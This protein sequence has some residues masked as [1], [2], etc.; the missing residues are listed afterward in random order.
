MPIYPGRNWLLS[1]ACPSLGAWDTYISN[2]SNSSNNSGA[3]GVVFPRFSRIQASKN[4]SCASRR[5][6]YSEYV[7]RFRNDSEFAPLGD[8]LAQPENTQN[9]RKTLAKAANSRLCLGNNG[10]I[11][12]SYPLPSLSPLYLGWRARYESHQSRKEGKTK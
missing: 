9:I 11:H 6:N 1:R 7:L 3:G 2:R 12:S 10:Q 4:S 5:A 8:N